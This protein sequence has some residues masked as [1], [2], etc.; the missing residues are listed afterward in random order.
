MEAAYYQ[1]YEITMSQF[2]SQTAIM[3]VFASI[4]QK[5]LMHFIKKQINNIPFI[6]WGCVN[7]KVS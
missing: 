2:I 4:A 3:E 6:F 5:L 7:K 1:I